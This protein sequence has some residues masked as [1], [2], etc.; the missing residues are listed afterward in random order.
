MSASPVQ[1]ADNR[2]LKKSIADI[3]SQLGSDKVKGYVIDLR[4]IRAA[5]STSDLGV[6]R[7]SQRGEI[8][9]DPRPRPQRPSASAP[10]RATLTRQAVILLINGGSASASDRRRRLQDHRRATLVAPASFGQGS[11]QTINPARL[12]QRRV[13]LTT[14]RYFTPPAARSRPRAF[15][16]NIEVLQDVPEETRRGRR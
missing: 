9:L 14:A 13:A 6:R 8:A 5:C 7:L 3:S 15:R 16:R 4:T 1:R 10:G 12:R 11:V 2:R